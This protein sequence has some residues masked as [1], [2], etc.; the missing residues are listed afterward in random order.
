VY[1]AHQRSVAIDDIF[2]F[3]VGRWL[4]RMDNPWEELVL[5][6]DGS[7]MTE[8]AVSP[9]VYHVNVVMRLEE[10]GKVAVQTARLVLDRSGI[11]RVE[12]NPCSRH[13]GL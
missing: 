5:L 1:L 10:G 7:A 12:T 2:R 4:E 6:P 11:L 13:E 3:N 9:R 8:T